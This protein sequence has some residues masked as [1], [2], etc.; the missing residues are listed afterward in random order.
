LV[1]GERSRLDPRVPERMVGSTREVDN[2]TAGNAGP[3][4]YGFSVRTRETL[5]FLRSG[6]GAE[7]LEIFAAAHA[8][9]RPRI[10]PLADWALIGTEYEARATLYRVEDGYEFWATDAGAYHVDPE[11]ARIEIPD[12]GDE[13]LREQRLWGIPVMLCYMHRGDFSLHAAAVEI[14]SGAVLLAAPSRY[15]KTTLAL[16][17][18]R[19][20]YR[21]LSEDLVC[22]RSEPSWEVLPGPAL[23]R[24]RTDVYDG[25]PPQGTHVVAARPDRVFLGLDDHRKGASGPVPIKAIAL[26]RESEELR[27]EPAKASAVLPDLWHLNFRLATDEDRAR[28]FQQLA[29][30]AGS[31]PSWNVHR[32]LRLESLD[33][34]VELIAKHL[35]L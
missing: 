23:V 27:I 10:E 16:A 34:T 8:R 25:H 15:G 3:S 19:H 14:G 32:P 31:V 24:M 35:D 20:G 9:A 7:P 21:I 12:G 26:L 18:H 4:I 5:R 1:L 11:K 29:R 13:I 6:G 17:F 2:V 33:K 28:S 30:L 22:C